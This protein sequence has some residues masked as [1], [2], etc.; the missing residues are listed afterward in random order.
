MIGQHKSFEFHSRNLNGRFILP[1]WLQNQDTQR[2]LPLE[3]KRKTAAKIDKGIKA[4]QAGE[5]SKIDKKEQ[6]LPA[7]S[8]LEAKMIH[9]RSLPLLKTGF[10]LS[11]EILSRGCIE[12]LEMK[13]CQTPK[14]Q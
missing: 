13:E 1:P 11:K 10:L 12:I 8:P 3:P 7:F 2:I 4:V 5:I 14:S 6:M 9:N